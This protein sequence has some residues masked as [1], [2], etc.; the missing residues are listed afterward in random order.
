MN[1]KNI[2]PDE[3]KM[4]SRRNFFEKLILILGGLMTAAVGL[5]MVGFVFKPLFKSLPPV[6]R[7]VGPVN[8]FKVGETVAVTFFRL[9]RCPGRGSRL[10]P[11]PGCA[12]KTPTASRPFPLAAPIWAARCAGGLK[13]S[14]S[15]VPVTAVF[16]IKTAR[17]RR[18]LRPLRCRVIRPGL[19]RIR[20]K[21]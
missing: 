13:R 8:S 2:R 21:F 11:P 10:K 19:L 9:R 1:E 5:P 18:G 3:T 4:I 6:W 7:S 12:G 17:S 15:C 16:T 20:L 14:C